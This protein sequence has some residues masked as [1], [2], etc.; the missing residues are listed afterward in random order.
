MKEDMTTP[1]LIIT[2]VFNYFGVPVELKD[3]NTRK[4]EK[5]NACQFS[6]Y[7]LRKYTRL[8]LAEAGFM[9]GRDHATTVHSCKKIN[10]EMTMYKDTRLFIEQINNRILANIQVDDFKYAYY[11]TE[12]V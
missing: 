12:N 7:F 10:Y 2:I 11:N 6:M 8:S 5:V 3:V 9:F 1:Q 4:R